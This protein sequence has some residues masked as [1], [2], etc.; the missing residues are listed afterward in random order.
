MPSVTSL[1]IKLNNPRLDLTMGGKGEVGNRV[2]SKLF[3]SASPS[4][5]HQK[6]KRLRIER[7]SFKTAGSTLP[8]MLPL[9]D[10][11]HLFLFSCSHTDRLCENI[12][13]LNLRLKSYCDLR[14]HKTSYP[15]AYDTFLKSLQSL[16]KL[17]LSCDGVDVDDWHPCDWPALLPHASELRCLDLRD[18]DP[19]LPFL[20]ATRGSLTGFRSFCMTASHLQQL[21]INGPS[22]R[23]ETWDMPR[24][25]DAFLVSQYLR[26][27]YGTT[28]LTCQNR[29]V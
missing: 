19:S 25:L 20:A 14:A 24:G 10:L 12:S 8:T 27:L 26:F 17:R 3:D 21:S 6:L 5:S 29:N 13:H 16:H 4:H 11:E 18:S 7:M 22:L 15:G 2:V 1:S 28:R 9:D 23:E